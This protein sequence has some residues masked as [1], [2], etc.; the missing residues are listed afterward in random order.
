MLHVLSAF[1]SGLSTHAVALYWETHTVGISCFPTPLL[2]IYCNFFN[3]LTAGAVRVC[4]YVCVRPV[5]LYWV[6]TVSVVVYWSGLVVV[7]NLFWMLWSSLPCWHLRHDSNRRENPF[8][9]FVACLIE[10]ASPAVPG[11][12]CLDRLMVSQGQS[13]INLKKR[14]GFKWLFEHGLLNSA[15]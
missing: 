7:I 12:Q 8:G 13:N 4:V 9:S 10:F 2:S 15:V 1:Q 14:N 6:V 5:T 3:C 11:C